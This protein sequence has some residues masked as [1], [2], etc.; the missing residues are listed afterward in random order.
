MRFGSCARGYDTGGN[1]SWI[2]E[3]AVQGAKVVVKSYY[4]C[5]KLESFDPIGDSPLFC[6]EAA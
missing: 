6:V 5:S 1:V 3:N 4:D 2:T